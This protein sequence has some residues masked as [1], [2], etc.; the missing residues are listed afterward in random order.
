MGTLSV[1][2]GGSFAGTVSAACFTNQTSP[3]FTLDINGSAR[4]TQSLSVNGTTQVGTLNSSG[5]ITGGGINIPGA[6]PINLG[7]DVSKTDGAAGRI[8]YQTYTSGAVDI[9]GAGAYPNRTVKVWDNVQ[10]PGSLT[11]NGNPVQ[12]FVTPTWINLPVNSNVTTGGFRA[13]YCLD[14]SGFCSISRHNLHIEQ[15]SCRCC[16]GVC[17]YARCLLQQ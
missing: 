15:P 8:G 2:G 11:V 10:I 4:V 3:L 17:N 14:A 7:S 6:L 1:G 5:I 13:Q 12:G 16:R 9:V